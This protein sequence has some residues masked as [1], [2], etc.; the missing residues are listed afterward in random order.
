MK[1]RV[2]IV[3][4]NSEQRMLLS[5]IFKDKYELDFASNGLNALEKLNTSL[6][7]LVISDMRM[8]EMDGVE[9]LK[10]IKIRFLALP[11]I[12][13]T[14]YGKIEDAVETMKMGAYNYVTKPFN[15]DELEMI[16]ERCLSESKKNLELNILKQCIPLYELLSCGPEAPDINKF[17]LLILETACEITSSNSGSILL[18]NEK[19]NVLEMVASL[20]LR[21]DIDRKIP[22]GERISGRVCSEGKAIILHSGLKEYEEFKAHIKRDEII[23]SMIIPLYAY[24]KVIGVLTLNRFSS[25]PYRFTENEKRSMEFFVSQISAIMIQ[26]EILKKN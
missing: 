7:D 18:L 5:K 12:M 9:L 17:P 13:M 11:V 21:D 16:V 1:E 24:G 10:E 26:I 3:E 14:G 22:M 8:P 4:D 25:F 2:L 19:G 6:Y 23:S 20:G 15:V